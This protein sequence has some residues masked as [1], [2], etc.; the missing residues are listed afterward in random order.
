MALLE[1]EEVDPNTPRFDLLPGEKVTRGPGD[2]DEG[3]RWRRLLDRLRGYRR[4]SVL[5]DQAPVWLPLFDL[6]APEGGR[7]AMCY[8]RRATASAGAE[9]GILGSGFGSAISATL[10]RG[11]EIETSD[12]PLRLAV[13]VRLTAVRYVSSRGRPDLVRVDVSTDQQQTQ[14]VQAEAPALPNPPG[15]PDCTVLE[16]ISLSEAPRAE[17]YS[18]TGRSE[19]TVSWDVSLGAELPGLSV[20]PK[21]TLAIE[22]AEEFEVT[23][24][25]PFGSDWMLCTMRGVSPIAPLTYRLAPQTAS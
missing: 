7:A 16:T 1:A 21:L 15:P 5:F 19:R 22:G 20:A 25:L 14:V 10:E 9:L 2:P 13:G 11:L 23:L 6:V 18:W 12:T 24:D 4:E 17:P 3:A 8:R